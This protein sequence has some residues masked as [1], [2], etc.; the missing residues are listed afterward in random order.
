VIL[1]HVTVLRSPADA[2]SSSRQRNQPAFARPNENSRTTSW[3][4]RSSSKRRAQQNKKKKIDSQSPPPLFRP[5]C[6]SPAVSPRSSM[7]TTKPEQFPVRRTLAL[8]PTLSREERA[9]T[10]CPGRTLTGERP[11]TSAAKA[12][13]FL[14]ARVRLRRA[15]FPLHGSAKATIPRQSTPPRKRLTYD[16][17]ILYLGAFLAVCPGLSPSLILLWTGGTR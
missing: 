9:K 4:D 8:S 12:V 17:R 10:S 7:L 1:L 6:I 5:A 3:N 15:S 16:Q 2:G 13:P 14:G 11:L